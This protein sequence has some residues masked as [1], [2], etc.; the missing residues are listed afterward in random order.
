MAEIEFQG[1]TKRFKDGTVAVDNL[2]LKVPDGEFL[3]LVGPS[4]CGKTT[5]LR[6]LAGLEDVTEGNIVLGDQ[7][8]NDLDPGKRDIAMVFQTYALFPHM[9]V[10]DNMA[11]PLQMR[12]VPKN[13]VAG[14]VRE[15]A[16]LLG[17]EP[18][19]DRRPNQLSGGQRQRV[20]MGR[21]IVRKPAAFLMDEPLSNLDAQ[22]RTEM[23]AELARLHQR[24]GVT[25]M[26]VTHDQV[27]AM[28]LGSRVVV[29]RHGM[30]Q[31]VGTPAEL[32]RRP[33]NAFV[34]RFIG[35]PTMNFMH[36][37]IDA[38]VLMF[39]GAKSGVVRERVG[40]RVGDVLVGVRPDA[41]RE[42]DGGEDDLTIRGEVEVV[43]DLGNETILHFQHG[44]RVP[45][46]VRAD[47][48]TVETFAARLRGGLSFRPGER[49]VFHAPAKELHLFD[50]DTGVVLDEAL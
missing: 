37:D 36:A 18:M 20:A 45:E 31:Q 33:R 26:Y 30:V 17:L 34:A 39:D 25:T 5:A 15:T 27:E 7:V 9:S 38:G 6:M 2:D 44:G 4:G 40:D 42:G 11:F 24:L 47:G 35:S 22:L 19:L 50:P 43:E 8:V 23:R 1:V 16:R 48:H 3:I 21:A 10:F 29:M 14:S 32:Y 49:V 41:W 12:R 46:L 13:E 28:T